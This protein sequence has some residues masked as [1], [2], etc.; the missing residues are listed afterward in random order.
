MN[1]MRQA[2]GVNPEADPA[3]SLPGTNGANGLAGGV[4]QRH[5]R[6]PGRFVDRASGEGGDGSGGEKELM[7]EKHNTGGQGSFPPSDMAELVEAL[8]F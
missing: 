1:A 8:P 2:G 5:R 6:A 3:R 7:H 4:D